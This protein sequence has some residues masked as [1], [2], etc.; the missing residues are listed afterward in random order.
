MQSM[1]QGDSGAG[2]LE[3]RVVDDV[4]EEQVSLMIHV[5][6]LK[7]IIKPA[8][9]GRLL[10]YEVE[11]V[12]AVVR[13]PS[14][15]RKH[16]RRAIDDESEPSELPSDIVLEERTEQIA[17]FN[18]IEDIER[19]D[20]GENYSQDLG[21]C[22]AKITKLEIILGSDDIFRISYINHKI[23]LAI[24]T[25]IISHPVICSKTLSKICDNI[26]SAIATNNATRWGSVFSI[27]EMYKKAFDRG[28]FKNMDCALPFD[29]STINL[30]L[31]ILKPA[32]AMNEP[33][34]SVQASEYR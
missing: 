8:F 13:P 11:K 5:D 12:L 26:R 6:M 18:D 1:F 20:D 16:R 15:L 28:V 3:A 4:E 17:R 10:P 7:N 14:K 30:L 24:R 33:K 19:F 23:N 21:I 32:Y 25:A 22:R 31:V 29:I 9:N 34:L 27:L 2:E